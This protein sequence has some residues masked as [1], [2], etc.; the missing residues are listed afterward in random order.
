MNWKGVN[1]IKFGLCLLFMIG[2]SSALAV[3]RKYSD[4][5]V[6]SKIKSPRGSGGYYL[7]DNCQKAYVL[8]PVEALVKFSEIQTDLDSALC[9]GTQGLINYITDSIIEIEK[10]R[11]DLAEEEKNIGNK[12]VPLR[13]IQDQC[14]A[15]SDQLLLAEERFI[16][17]NGQARQVE[18]KLNFKN[19]ELA[20]CVRDNGADHYSC[21]FLKMD[22]SEL[23]DKLTKAK[24]NETLLENQKQM[25]LSRSEICEK[26]VQLYIEKSKLNTKDYQKLKESLMTLMAN[27]QRILN[28]QIKKEAEEPG[29]IIGVNFLSGF[30]DYI[31]EYKDL[32][33]KLMGE[34]EFVQMPLKNASIQFQLIEEGRKAG[35]PIILQSRITGLVTEKNDQ[36]LISSELTAKGQASVSQLFGQGVGG[37]VVVN[38]LAVCKMARQKG[39]NNPSDLRSSDVASLLRPTATYEYETQV[40]RRLLISFEETHLYQLIKKNTSGSS[41][42]FKSKSVSSLTESSE[43]S[44]WLEIEFSSE[45]GDHKFVDTNQ[46]AMDIRKEFVDA[47]ISKVAKSYLSDEQVELIEGGKSISDSM[48]PVLKTC[49]HKYC[50]AAGV[51]L[52]IGNAVFGGNIQEAN[53]TKMVKSKE[54]VKIQDLQ[55][56]T[57]YGTQIFNSSGS[58]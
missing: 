53:M 20:N 36:T 49:K 3:P 12:D 9:A 32:N 1:M 39:L 38:R 29:G 35:Y 48:K 6:N 37:N 14:S 21:N 5:S 22:V 30:Q 19:E 25:L 55:M 57:H 40:N 56:V 7:S 58:K 41:G 18:D 43:A 8:P 27:Y 2:T 26:R 46:M 50:K 17:M 16:L 13:K 31:E 45:D 10:V 23:K 47:A 11:K 51:V 28:E 42:L 24:S 54:K 34:I 52:D 4:C 33:Q 44:K 15:L